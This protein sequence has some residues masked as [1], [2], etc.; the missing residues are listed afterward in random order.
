MRYSIITLA[1]NQVEI[2]GNA[3]AFELLSTT[4][5]SRG[6][7]MRQIGQEIDLGSS[8]E[9]NVLTLGPMTMEASADRMIVVE[10]PFVSGYECSSCGGR[11]VVNCENCQG[12]G[13]SV[14]VKDGKCSR[15]QGSK[16]MKCPACDGK[17]GTIVVPEVSERRPTTG[18]IVSVGPKITQYARGESVLYPSFAG[19]VLDLEAT[20]IDGNAVVAAIRILQE[21]DILAKVS[22]HLELRRVKK[23]AAL[24]SAA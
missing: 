22:G 19:H 21:S 15:C 7:K 18:Q 12:T 10:D 24:G 20:D 16:V 6:E 9:N 4:I 14:I 23:S 5:E 17:G 2:A 8:L 11:G 13:K 1:E 3:V